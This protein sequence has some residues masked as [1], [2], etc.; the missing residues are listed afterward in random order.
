MQTFDNE[1]TFFCLYFC[2]IISLLREK[3]L[4]FLKDRCL[5]IFILLVV[6]LGLSLSP[7]ILDAKVQLV[8]SL[9]IINLYGSL[10][11]TIWIHTILEQWD[12]HAH[13]ESVA[14]S[15]NMS[16]CL[17]YTSSQV[18]KSSW[19]HMICSICESQDQIWTIGQLTKFLTQSESNDANFQKNK[20]AKINA[21]DIHSLFREEP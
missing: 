19:E 18:I 5:Q 1:L 21:T 20:N 17:H 9:Q 12:Y 13:H 8:P 4:I 10:T 2:L 3:V 16:A 11:C 14:N 15:L 6:V 7:K